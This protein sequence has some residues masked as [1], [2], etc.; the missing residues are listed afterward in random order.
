MY[1]LLINLISG[2]H[3][4]DSCRDKWERGSDRL[5]INWRGSQF[6]GERGEY[7]SQLRRGRLQ[8]ISAGGGDS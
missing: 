5:R 1:E 8:M 3:D 2:R 7:F 4:A 6:M